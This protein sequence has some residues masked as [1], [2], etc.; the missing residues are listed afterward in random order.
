MYNIHSSPNT[1]LHLLKVGTNFVYNI[2]TN[3]NTDLYLLIDIIGRSPGHEKYF[4]FPVVFVNFA[5][6]AALSLH[7]L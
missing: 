7:L 3:S 1:D 5:S 4:F 2:H 6:L